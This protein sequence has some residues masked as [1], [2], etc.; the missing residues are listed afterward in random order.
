[1]PKKGYK[2]TEEHKK[3]LSLSKIGN[4]NP[5][6]EPVARKKIS[7][8]RKRYFLNQDNRIKLSEMYRG[9]KNWNWQG[10]ISYNPYSIDWT[11]SLRISIRERDKYTCQLCNDKQGDYAF[12][13]HHIDYNKHNCCPDNL[14]T[15][16]HSCHSKTNN[17]REY[18]INYFKGKQ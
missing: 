3:K 1:M 12:S 10:G 13:V 14:I 6:K 17:H 15:L 5:M 7:E 16:C 18:W 8:A 4:K 11:N 9:N 2:Q